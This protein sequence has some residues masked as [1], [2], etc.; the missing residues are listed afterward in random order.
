MILVELLVVLVVIAVLAALLLP[1]MEHETDR[2]Y[3]RMDCMNNLRQVG[4]AFR[5]WAMDH[6]DKFPMEIPETNGGSMEFDTGSNLFRHFQVISNELSTPK[7]LVCYAEW[8]SPGITAATNFSTAFANSNI[9]YFVGVDADQSNPRMI[10][11]GDHNITNGLPVQNGILPLT[12][13]Q[14]AS[15][16][17]E[18]HKNRG[19]VLFADGSVQL[20]NTPKLRE[21]IKNSGVGTNRLQ[22][23]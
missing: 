23:P 16:T 12:T 1:G 5:V 3:A 17:A 11:G 18:I 2:D 15:W 8:Y 19:N 14:L 20:A 6:N 22:M 13:K 10:L 21:M 9:G 4:L 7:V